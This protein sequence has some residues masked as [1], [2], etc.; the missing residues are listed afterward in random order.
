[1]HHSA[2]KAFYLWR[3]N[4]VLPYAIK[5]SKI[6]VTSA[7]IQL[8]FRLWAGVHNLQPSVKVYA[9]VHT[10]FTVKHKF[11]RPCINKYSFNYC[12]RILSIKTAK[13]TCGSRLSSM[14]GSRTEAMLAAVLHKHRRNVAG[15]SEKAAQPCSGAIWQTFALLYAY[16]LLSHNTFRFVS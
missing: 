2:K 1:M 10:W 6:L 4:G 9:A 11:W 3:F 14:C 7:Y 12:M 16:N 5:L 8:R 15:N 13:Q